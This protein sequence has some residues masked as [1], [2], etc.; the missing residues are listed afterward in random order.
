MASFTRKLKKLQRLRA[1][2]AG[3]IE[4]RIAELRR[5]M[6][7]APNFAQIVTHYLDALSQDRAFMAAGA[8]RPNERLISIARIALKTYFEHTQPLDTVLYHLEREHLWHGAIVFRTGLLGLVVY[9][10]DVNRGVCVAVGA[11]GRIVHYFRFSI[12]EEM[13]DP[14]DPD[15]T[16][17]ILHRKK[18]PGPPN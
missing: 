14:I 7:E 15:T 4:E 17:L 11:P 18:Q 6:L 1:A 2:T 5:L 9:F 16:R 12:P 10:E 8:R 3:T 13:V